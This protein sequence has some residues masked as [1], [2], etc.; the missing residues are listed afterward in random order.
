MNIR[1]GTM[2]KARAKGKAGTKRVPRVEAFKGLAVTFTPGNTREAEKF[3]E[4][5]A[6]R[7]DGGAKVPGR[8]EADD[9]GGG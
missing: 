2:G 3:R 7:D 9:A 8:G 5:K 1:V 4:K 6:A